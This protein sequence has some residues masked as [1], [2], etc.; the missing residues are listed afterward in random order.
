MLLASWNVNG[1]RA[2][3]K[4]GF[5]DWLDAF[6]PDVLLLQETK[7]RKED[8][9][10]ELQ[11]VEGYEVRYHSAEKKGYSGVALYAREEPDEWVVGVGDPELDR[12]GRFLGARFGDLV[13]ASAYF[14]NSQAE[15]A[16][17]EYRQQ[18]NRAVHAYLDAQRD[19]GRNVA[20]GGDYNVSHM[21][22][23]LARPKQNQ[24][25]PG[26]LPEEREWMT[27]FLESGYVD[28][29]RRLNPELADAYSW[30]SYRAGARGRNVGWRLDYFC[31]DE[32]LWPRVKS[33]GI[34]AE[35]M[36]SDHCPVVL[37]LD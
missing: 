23:D 13:V 25:N 35:V 6:S 29:F 32:A 31:V 3:A 36:G 8:L 24:R 21:P 16:R 1:L 19:A 37:E 30:W 22:I 9:P 33:A 7:A 17:L 12:E 4:K 5:A 11:S 34:L 27:E 20:L 26:Y 2:V 18:F 14:P 28:T 10:E 15:G